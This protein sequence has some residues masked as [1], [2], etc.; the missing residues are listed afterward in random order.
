MSQGIYS[1]KDN[2]EFVYTMGDHEETLPVKS[3]DMSMK[4]KLTLTRFGGT[5]GTLK[6]DEKSF[7]ILFWVSHYIGIKNVLMHLVLIVR[8]YTLEKIL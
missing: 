2:L 7:S 8:A 6:F 5:F 1:S 3:D 4:T